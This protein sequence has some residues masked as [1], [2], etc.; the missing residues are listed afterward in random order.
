MTPK[1]RVTLLPPRGES[2]QEAW[3]QRAGDSQIAGNM[4]AACPGQFAFR[5]SDLLFDGGDFIADGRFV[6]VSPAVLSRNI[7]HTVSDEAQLRAVLQR[8][9]GR[10]VILMPGA[11]DH[12]VGMF[13][14]SAGD[15]GMVIADPSLARPLFAADAASA[16]VLAGGANFSPATQKRFD[17][18]AA[19]ATA[20]GYRVTRIPVVTAA[21]GKMYLTYVNVILDQQAGHRIV[22]MPTFTDQPRLNA[23]ATGVWKSLGYEVRPI[24]CTTV[25]P[26]GGTLHCLANVVTRAAE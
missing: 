18:V 10:E 3:P 19:V 12:H 8:E 2:Q 7:Q 26:R 24:D 16:H 17:S 15:G 23:A 9:L 13:M 14:M 11:P 6:F 4:A 22:Y 20:C 5:R 1:D 25:F 21:E